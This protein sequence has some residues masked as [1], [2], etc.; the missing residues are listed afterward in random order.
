MGSDCECGGDSEAYDF[1]GV[2]RKLS[3]S[4]PI[5]SS[6]YQDIAST[7]TIRLKVNTNLRTTSRLVYCVK[8]SWFDWWKSSLV[9]AALHN[10]LFGLFPLST[11][12]WLMQQVIRHRHDPQLQLFILEAVVDIEYHTISGIDDLPVVE[13]PDNEF[14]NDQDEGK[15][16]LDFDAPKNA[17]EERII[18]LKICYSKVTSISILKSILEKTSLFVLQKLNYLKMIVHLLNLNNL[19][20]NRTLDL[21]KM[22]VA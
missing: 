6:T 18:V 4:T 8:N 16:E 17:L 3:T 10:V 14:L 5:H 21:N 15:D 20:W 12:L 2:S 22:S 7:S 19:N 9:L 13:L 1:S 11:I